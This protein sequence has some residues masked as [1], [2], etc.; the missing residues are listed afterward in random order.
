MAT[1]REARVRVLPRRRWKYPGL[2]A[3]GVGDRDGCDNPIALSPK[4]PRRSSSG[5]GVSDSAYLPLLDR[6]SIGPRCLHVG[7]LATGKILETTP[8]H[9]KRVVNGGHDIPV[10]RL[11]CRSPV[12]DL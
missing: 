5:A 12:R 10:V 9:V 6:G 7:A 3:E 11:S 1:G 2:S 8:R 4:D